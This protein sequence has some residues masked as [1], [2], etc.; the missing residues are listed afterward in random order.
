MAV[1]DFSKTAL[2]GQV[3]AKFTLS[4]QFAG[5]RT[6]SLAHEL[7]AEVIMHVTVP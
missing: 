7:P 3:G 1:V 5:P 4:L 6:R 2:T